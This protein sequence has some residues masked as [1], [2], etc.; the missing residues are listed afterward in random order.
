MVWHRRAAGT[1]E[2]DSLDGADSDTS[3][4]SAE[5]YMSSAAGDQTPSDALRVRVRKVL[6]THVAA[7][8]RAGTSVDS[9]LQLIVKQCKDATFVMA[10]LE[11]A[12]IGFG[13][14]IGIIASLDEFSQNGRRNT[15]SKHTYAK[16]RSFRVGSPASSGGSNQQHTQQTT[17]TSSN[18]STRTHA[19]EEHHGRGRAAS[20]GT[21]GSG[22]P[23][24][25]TLYSVDALDQGGQDDQG[26]DDYQTKL[27]A[28]EMYELLPRGHANRQDTHSAAGG[29][30]DYRWW[31]NSAPSDDTN[32]AAP[33]QL[34]MTRA[35]RW[36]S[37]REAQTEPFSVPGDVSVGA[38]ASTVHT[39]GLAPERTSAIG[40][41]AA[42]AVQWQSVAS[43]PQAT[44]TKPGDVV[45][46]SSGPTSTAT[47]GSRADMPD[48]SVP[49]PSVNRSSTR[50]S[51][52][53]PR[54]MHPSGPRNE[55]A[56]KLAPQPTSSAADAVLLDLLAQGYGD[57]AELGMQSAYPVDAGS[58]QPNQLPVYAIPS[59]A[60]NGNNGDN[61]NTRPNVAPP[62]YYSQPADATS[63]PT[64]SNASMPIYA[65]PAESA[66]GSTDSL[67]MPI[68]A[69]PT[70]LISN[71]D[72]FSAMPVYA[73]P[74]DANH[75]PVA[76]DQPSVYAQPSDS[77]G[78][79]ATPSGQQ[80]PIYAQPA[81]AID[82]TVDLS[83]YAEAGDA[84]HVPAN[85][86]SESFM[87]QVLEAKEKIRASELGRVAGSSNDASWR[88]PATHSPVKGLSAAFS[89]RT[90]EPRPPS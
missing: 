73:Q 18:T 57:P 85:Q 27:T 54:T 50:P 38:G 87:A 4:A 25:E 65:Q 89:V 41:R 33:P 49:V 23:T 24:L 46:T 2:L 13:D 40:A 21:D 15:F 17:N 81:D 56:R 74:A 22:I 14:A 34:P 84:V 63:N 64:A 7:F 72:S 82:T 60:N 1:V 62:H 61:G 12:G 58:T 78:S 71:S 68:Y 51:S 75:Q 36:S 16:L 79:A 52:G 70:A 69:Q 48:Y 90:Y 8:A 30:G 11:K 88:H 9:I 37:G 19:G 28:H 29:L 80:L 66:N 76:S 6:G 20:P 3:I 55:A 42:A 43:L 35:P 5:T 86:P 77:I 39:R 45:Y 53:P 44:N 47:A 31:T 32:T 67:A 83:I 26:H 59:D 10:V